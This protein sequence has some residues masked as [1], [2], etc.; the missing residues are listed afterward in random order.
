MRT[1]ANQ[2]SSS[3]P[4]LT[5]QSGDIQ[6]SVTRSTRFSSRAYR[7]QSVPEDALQRI[8]EAWVDAFD[9]AAAR[10]MLDLPEGVEPVAF[11]PLSYSAEAPRG[12]RVKRSVGELIHYSRW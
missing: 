8:L 3:Y 1:F 5:N 2:R 10:E 7:Q 4:V 11:T 9:C 12:H 6:S